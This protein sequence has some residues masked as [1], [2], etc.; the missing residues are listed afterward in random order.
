MLK[1]ALATLLWT[2]I[3]A[4]PGL[5]LAGLLWALSGWYLM[6]WAVEAR[7]EASRNAPKSTF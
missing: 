5:A 1:Y 3:T 4:D 7:Q 2:V 6:A